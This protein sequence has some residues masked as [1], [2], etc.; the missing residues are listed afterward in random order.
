MSFSEHSI[1]FSIFGD[2]QLDAPYVSCQFDKDNLYSLIWEALNLSHVSIYFSIYFFLTIPESN[3]IPNT[4][5]TADVEHVYL[6]L[7]LYVGRRLRYTHCVFPVLTFLFF[8]ATMFILLY[9]PFRFTIDR[10]KLNVYDICLSRN[11][12]L[13][14]KS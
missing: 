9:F 2:A 5:T 10:R 11:L 3:R 1:R 14:K 13:V 12:I 8:V 6:S 4:C 7:L